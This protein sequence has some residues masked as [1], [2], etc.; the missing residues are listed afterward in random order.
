MTLTFKTSSIKIRKFF[1]YWFLSFL[2][3]KIL[4]TIFLGGGGVGVAMI[5]KT[6]MT[7]INS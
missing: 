4:M 7:I 1:R 3:E 5:N 2:F 6:I